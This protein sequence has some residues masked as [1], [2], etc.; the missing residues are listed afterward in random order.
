M[1]TVTYIKKSTLSFPN[2]WNDFAMVKDNGGRWFPSD[3]T[4]AYASE[5]LTGH[6]SPSRAWPLSYAKPMLSQKF[7]KLVVE[8]DPVLAVKIGIA[9]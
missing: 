8:H 5:F 1:K 7:A 4:P 9:E 2:L 3:N 6:R